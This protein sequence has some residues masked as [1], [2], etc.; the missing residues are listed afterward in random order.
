MSIVAHNSKYLADKKPFFKHF[1]ARDL[2]ITAVRSVAIQGLM[3]FNGFVA[4][5]EFDETDDEDTASEDEGLEM[6]KK[7]NKKKYEEE[8]E[9]KEFE[10]P[11]IDEFSATCTKSFFKSLSITT[12]LRS[13]EEVAIHFCQPKLVRKLI[14]DV[15]KSAL[16]KYS[17]SASKAKAASL[18]LQ[19]GMRANFL[20]HIAIFVIE[21]TQQIVL[22]LYKRFIG[23][24]KSTNKKIAPES[25]ASPKKNLRSKDCDKKDK[26]DKECSDIELFLGIT[27]KNATRCGLSVVTGGIGAAVGTLI[28]PGLGTVI[29]ATIGDTISY[30]L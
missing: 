6:T 21:E 5:L 11:T 25:T 2:T 20:S 29:G 3:V 19:T 30:A 28:R 15:S 8:E 7:K 14:K 23:S 24:C 18:M 16:R 1:Y 17:R 26:K 9:K 10:F 4:S 12:C 27:A 22:I 13:L